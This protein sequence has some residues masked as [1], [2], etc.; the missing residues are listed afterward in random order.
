MRLSCV[1]ALCVLQYTCVCSWRVSVDAVIVG[2]FQLLL[3]VDVFVW[4]SIYYC[5]MSHASRCCIRAFLSEGQNCKQKF[6]IATPA[7]VRGVA[8]CKDCLKPRCIYSPYAV[9]QM[10]PTLPPPSRDTWDDFVLTTAI[11]I[12]KYRAMARERLHDAK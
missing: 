5:R 8:V 12:Q 11:D 4:V 9:S 6:K 1:L 10:K 2:V 7:R 3:V